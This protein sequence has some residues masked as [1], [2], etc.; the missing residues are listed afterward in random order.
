MFYIQMFTVIIYLSNPSKK[1]V[2]SIDVL[3]QTGP[4]WN[5]CEEYYRRSFC[6]DLSLFYM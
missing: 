3:V 4:R 5:I 1:Q 6:I 2:L